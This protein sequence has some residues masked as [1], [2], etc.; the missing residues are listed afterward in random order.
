MEFIFSGKITAEDYIQFN[1]THNKKSISSRIIKII[2]CLLII[3]VVILFF[4]N[5]NDY[6]NNVKMFESNN[7]IDKPLLLSVVIEFIGAIF[8]IIVFVLVYTIFVY[9]ILPIIYRKTY[10]SNK[11]LNELQNY[12]IN[13]KEIIINSE[14]GNIIIQ[15]EK[16]FKIIYDKD[17]IYI[18]IGSNMAY[19]IKSKF[20]ENI[21]QFKELCEYLKDK[22]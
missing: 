11:M 6:F 20:F 10:N 4:V 5:L 12:K 17:S 21:N 18:Y 9:I 8:P 13:E 3:L 22:Y 15:K 7:G 14:N 1:K 2:F 19:I 16:I